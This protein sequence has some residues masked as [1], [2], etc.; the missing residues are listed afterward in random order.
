MRTR[1]IVVL[2]PRVSTAVGKKF[3]KPLAARCMCCMKANSQTRGSFAASL[4]PLNVLVWWRAPTVSARMRSWASCRSSSV[5]QR[6]WRGSSGSTKTEQTAT[7]KVT[8][9]WRMKSHCQPVMP[10]RSSMPWK[11]PA[12]IRPAK[13]VARMFP[14]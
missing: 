4:T 8:A 13:A 5:S 6:V 3:L 12:A 1:V 2:K 7:T 11:I 9:P 10:A 14:V